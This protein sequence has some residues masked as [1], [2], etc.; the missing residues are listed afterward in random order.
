MTQQWQQQWQDYSEK[1]LQLSPREQYLIVLT[2][3]VAIIFI[4]FHLFIDSNLVES[5]R[6]SKQLVQF[7]SQNKALKAF[8]SRISSSVKKRSK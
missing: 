2:G 5:Q 3:L 8:G 7:K 6:L 4:I 1:Y